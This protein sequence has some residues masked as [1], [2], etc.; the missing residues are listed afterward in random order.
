[1][2][3]RELIDELIAAWQSGDAVRASAFFA[4]E[5][6]YVESGASILG[7]EAI[8]AHFRRF[9]RDGPS[10]HFEA[11][12]IVTE[13]DRAALAFRFSIKGAEGAWSERAGCALVH[14]RDGLIVQ[15]REYDG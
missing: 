1:M 10:W 4:P 3:M 13:G 15:W 9:F 7:R 14:R 6:E 8:L 2:T 5:G 11:D 12:E